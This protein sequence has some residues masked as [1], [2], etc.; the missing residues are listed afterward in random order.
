MVLGQ[1]LVNEGCQLRFAHG[2]HFGGRQLAAFEQHECG[3]AADA[4]FGG[5]LAV[6]VH[7]HLGDLQFAVVSGGN[8]VQDGGDH[9]AWTAPCGPVVDQ[10]RLVSKQDVG[11]ESGVGDVFDQVA[12]HGVFLLSIGDTDTVGALWQKASTPMKTLSIDVVSDVVCPWCYIGKRRLEGALQLW[13]DKH[14]D[15]VPQVRW[16]PFQLNP[17]LAQEGISR[18]TYVLQK[19]GDRAASVYDRVTLVAKEVGLNLAIDRIQQQPNT[20]LPHSLISA[21]GQGDT[22]TQ[23]VEALF[24]AYFVQGQDL[25][26]AQVLAE[27][28]TNA[29]MAQEVVQQALSDT[30]LHEQIRASDQA[31]REMGI[32]GVPFFIFNRKVGVSG[33]H[34]SES[35]LQAME[36]ALAE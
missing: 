32:T 11:F 8:F 29:G 34:E 18:H 33:A 13:A 21:A 22:Q 19:F 9:L 5:N 23:M 12:G 3:N 17:D 35:L 1:L 26:Q 16:H 14:P 10:H 30:V 2:A 4:K 7:I 20:V 28:A 15:V 27:I 24:E 36:Q 31:A 6:F 25:T